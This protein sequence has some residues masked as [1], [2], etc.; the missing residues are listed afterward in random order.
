MKLVMIT[1]LTV[2]SATSFAQFQTELEKCA[3]DNSKEIL[4][5]VK[6]TVG[7]KNGNQLRGT[8]EMVKIACLDQQGLAVKEGLSQEDAEKVIRQAVRLSAAELFE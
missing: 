2:L 1:L 7:L 5:I 6:E 4:T 8:V 3:Y